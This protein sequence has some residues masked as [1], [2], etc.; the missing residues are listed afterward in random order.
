MGGAVLIVDISLVILASVLIA[1]LAVGRREMWRFSLAVLAGISIILWAS[2]S[3]L[4]ILGI[5]FVMPMMILL[6]CLTGCSLWAVALRG[7]RDAGQSNSP[8][9]EKG[10]SRNGLWKTRVVV[11]MLIVVALPTL[12]RMTFNGPSFSVE[13]LA[14][15]APFAANA[16]QRGDLAITGP[17]WLAYLPFNTDTVSLWFS[18]HTHADGVAVLSSFYWLILLAAGIVWIL[19]ETKS[20]LGAGILTITMAVASG[21]VSAESRR[22]ASPDLAGAALVMA[23]IAFIVHSGSTH[24]I[25]Q[26]RVN[27]MYAGLLTG[28]AVGSKILFTSAAVTA[29]LWILIIQPG[30]LSSASRWSPA[31]LFTACAFLTGLPWYFRTYMLSGN[32]LFPAEWGLFQGPF[33]AEYQRQTSI[34]G[35][36]VEHRRAMSEWRDLVKEYCDWPASIFIL[37]VGGYLMQGI[38]W[39]RKRN[40]KSEMNLRAVGLIF[41]SGLIFAMVLPFAPF[42]ATPDVP[43]G[44]PLNLARY[45]ILPFVLGLLLWFMAVANTTTGFLISA[46]A[47]A[48]SYPETNLWIILSAFAI[49][50]AVA[51]LWSRIGTIIRKAMARPWIVFLLILSGIG[52]ISFWVPAV[53]Q[54]TDK[55]MSAYKLDEGPVG[56]GWDGLDKLPVGSRV[57]WFGPM[58]LIYPCYGRRLQ[59][60]PLAV[61]TD[62]SI[63][64]PLHERWRENPLGV[65]WWE[66]ATPTSASVLVENLTLCNVDYVLLQK[67]GDN[68]PQ[69]DSLLQV[70]NRVPV[71]DD[72]FSRIR[73][74]SRGQDGRLR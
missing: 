32:P 42:S 65:R 26:L 14:Y 56:L 62:G 71:F 6:V 48:A 27:M 30:K 10:A 68:W 12:A 4:G 44:I 9:I 2:T 43:D 5:L 53:Q 66:R 61:N 72:G 67:I 31:L 39:I 16:I 47:L 23:G 74:L 59:L 69:Q 13:D 20:A 1:D 52:V 64:R 49:G 70:A 33:S 19:R 36:L 21:V 46:S 15:H 73:R 55:N 29:L 45:G 25:R 58:N 60:K 35:W 63:L 40:T 51:A 11:P 22:Y 38:M 57:T 41:L 24:D 18:L 37:S 50:A 54:A 28:L 34:I 17:F 8:S 7:T 3:I